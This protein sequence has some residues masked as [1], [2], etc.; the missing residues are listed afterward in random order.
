M[1]K[2]DTYTKLI[3]EVCHHDGK[4]FRN[5]VETNQWDCSLD[6]MHEMWVQLLR[7]AG[8]HVKDYYDILFT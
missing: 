3:L 7:G 6:D 5:V 8:Y 1:S 2:I 4:T